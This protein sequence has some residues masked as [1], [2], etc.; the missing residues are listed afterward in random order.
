MSKRSG[1][2][3]NRIDST[4][5]CRPSLTV[6]Y[7]VMRRA[8]PATR[9]G[10]MEQTNATGPILDKANSIGCAPT[11]P[12][13]RRI[14]AGGMIGHILNRGVGRIRLFVEDA[15]FEGFEH[16]PLGRDQQ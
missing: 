11:M 3:L 12:G 13:T 9:L 16:R 7:R 14:T 5:R 2:L 8:R 10:G 6:N 4:S 15:N 1:P